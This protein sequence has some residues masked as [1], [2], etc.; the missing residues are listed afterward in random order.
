MHK[1]LQPRDD[2]NKLY[3]SRKERGRGLASH[4]DCVD[5]LIRLP[6]AYIK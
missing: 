4:D 2:I 5:V 1:A 3:V 6:H